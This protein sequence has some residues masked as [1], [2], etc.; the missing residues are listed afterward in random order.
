MKIAGVKILLVVCLLFFIIS[1]AT[2]RDLSF[3]EQSS[4]LLSLKTRSYLSPSKWF[5]KD[6]I[7][8]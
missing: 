1:G 2:A 6:K 3:K 7:R 8:N 5:V 4:E